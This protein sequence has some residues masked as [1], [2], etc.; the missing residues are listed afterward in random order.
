MNIYV[1]NTYIKG[2]GVFVGKF[3]EN[4]LKNGIDKKAVE[5]KEKE[6]G[7]KYTNTKIIKEKGVTKLAI[8]VCNVEDF[9]I[10]E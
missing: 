4:D 3:S 6:T 7:L 2:L 1:E 10:W 8:W 5:K 9:K